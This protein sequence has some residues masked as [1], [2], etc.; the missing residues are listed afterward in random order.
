M[1]TTIRPNVSKQGAH[2][3]CPWR[4]EYNVRRGRGGIG[5]L[6]VRRGQ[7]ANGVYGLFLLLVKSGEYR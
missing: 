6:E 5:A 2:L 4:S 7:S 3:T 1:N